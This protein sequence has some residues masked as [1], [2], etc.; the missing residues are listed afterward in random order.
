MNK[1][2]LIYIAST[3]VIALSVLAM[4]HFLPVNSSRL[5]KTTT[6]ESNRKETVNF[7]PKINFFK[8]ESDSEKKF[9][10]TKRKENENKSDFNQNNTETIVNPLPE[11]NENQE[12]NYLKDIFSQSK[13]TSPQNIESGCSTC[14][15]EQDEN[16]GNDCKREMQK[17]LAGTPY[18]EWDNFKNSDI[19]K[20]TMDDY[21]QSIEE[22]T[23][24]L[25]KSS[26]LF[27]SLSK[28][29]L[30]GFGFIKAAKAFACSCS[31]CCN[32][33]GCHCAHP[34]CCVCCPACCG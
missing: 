2:N 11:E 22:K 26:R 23:S 5:P 19:Y 33:H 15:T 32:S 24:F 9:E 28:N 25:N 30:T 13:S 1:K 18:N 8:K 31:S 16:L 7:Q 6:K 10:K 29:I 17:I 20:E 14:G 12:S 21:F 4:N 34:C 27:C 3:L